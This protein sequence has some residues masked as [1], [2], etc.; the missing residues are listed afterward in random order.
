MFF[1]YLITFL[2]SAV[3]F[4]FAFPLAV[5][6]YKFSYIET[7]SLTISGGILGV[8][9]F[10]FLTDYIVMLWTYFIT[11]TKLNKIKLFSKKTNVNAKKFTFK[12]KTIVKVKKNYGLIG[13]AI[14]T[15]ILL[16]IPVGTFISL[17]YFPER[18][19]T[20]SYLIISV[21]LWANI[22]SFILYKM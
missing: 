8:F 13:L 5:Y 9:V 18:N 3:K 14:L 7:L 1:K 6:Q 10:A 12:N 21:I 20:I 15:P 11:I 16:S 2:F 22:I 4:A 19:K 17:R